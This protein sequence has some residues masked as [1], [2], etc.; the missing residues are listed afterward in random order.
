MNILFKIF[1]NDQ[2][3]LTNMLEIAGYTITGLMKE[4]IIMILNG[5]IACN[6][7]STYFKMMSSILEDIYSYKL[8][9]RTFEASYNNNHKYIS[10][11]D[12]KRFISIEECSEENQNSSLLKSICDGGKI[13]N[14][15]LYSTTEKIN[16]N[17]VSYIAMNGVFKLKMTMVQKED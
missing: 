5:F 10:N 3:L 14:E 17:S 1:N 6:G 12:K 13:D 15:K 7:K 16:V 8:N 4:P 9:N 11:I 2:V